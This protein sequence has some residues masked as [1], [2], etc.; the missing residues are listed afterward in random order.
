MQKF[1]KAISK[2]VADPLTWIH[3][4]AEG[5]VEFRSILYIP[6]TAPSDLYGKPSLVSARD[7]RPVL[8]RLQ[9]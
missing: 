2:D 3:F 7:P 1:F 8:Y 5:E 4:T 6:T 9:Q